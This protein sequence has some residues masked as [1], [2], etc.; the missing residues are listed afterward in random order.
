MEFKVIK[1]RE[2]FQF[3]PPIQTSGDWMI[4]ITSLEVYI[5]VFNIT[6][7]DNKFEVFKFPAEKRGGI[8]YEKIRDEIERDLGNSNITATDS[9]DDKIGPIIIKEYREQVTKRMEDGGQMNILSGYR[10]SVFQDFEKYLRTEIDLR[11]D[12]IRL[13]FG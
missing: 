3:N 9:Q 6:E 4:G 12:D 11:G 2:T 7:E 5:S 10:S 13:V 8:T 1:P